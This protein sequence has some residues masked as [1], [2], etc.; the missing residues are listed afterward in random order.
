MNEKIKNDYPD[1]LKSTRATY[2]KVKNY[3]KVTALGRT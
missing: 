1:R 2:A 3:D